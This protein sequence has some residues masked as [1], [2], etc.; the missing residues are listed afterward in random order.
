M[1]IRYMYISYIIYI[2]YIYIYIYIPKYMYIYTWV[3]NTNRHD[4]SFDKRYLNLAVSYF[5]D[6]CF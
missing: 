4:I 5:L 1:Y 6:Q 2:I 3:N